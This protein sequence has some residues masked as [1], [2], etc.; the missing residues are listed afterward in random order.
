MIGEKSLTGSVCG[1]LM[2]TRGWRLLVLDRERNG[3]DREGLGI[4]FS[5]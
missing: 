3:D 4:G 2:L 5:I 1:P